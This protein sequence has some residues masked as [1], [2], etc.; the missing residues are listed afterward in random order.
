MA[1]LGQRFGPGENLF[2]LKRLISYAFPISLVSGP[3]SGASDRYSDYPNRLQDAG[4][5]IKEATSLSGSCQMAELSSTRLLF[6]R[7]PSA[8]S[9]VPHLAAAA[10]RQS[11]RD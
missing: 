6:S 7:F 5:T 8:M 1:R 11:S 10:S 3:A 2:I 4:Y 9:L